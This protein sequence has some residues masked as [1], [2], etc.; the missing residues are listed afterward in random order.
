MST[1]VNN[2][3]SVAAAVYRQEKAISACILLEWAVQSRLPAVTLRYADI[4]RGSD[5][6]V[7]RDMIDIVEW[8]EGP[9]KT[10]GAER[11]ACAHALLGL[12]IAY[13]RAR[14]VEALGIA[15]LSSY[16]R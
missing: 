3:G 12:Y 5:A 6:D 11:C 13:Q 2:V 16:F 15:L 4:N 10:I 8:E 1:N 9:S 7:L 14:L